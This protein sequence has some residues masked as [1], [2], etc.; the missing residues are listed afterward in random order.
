MHTLIG[1]GLQW[2][3]LNLPPTHRPLKALVYKENGII[4]LQQGS[5]QRHFA[6]ELRDIDFA[7]HT[8]ITFSELIWEEVLRSGVGHNFTYLTNI[9]V[10]AGISAGLRLVDA[11]GEAVDEYLAR[12][13]VSPDVL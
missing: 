10:N 3:R 5:P 9:M 4:L 1:F 7:A 11:N 2:V 13:G 8:T 6:R 12:T